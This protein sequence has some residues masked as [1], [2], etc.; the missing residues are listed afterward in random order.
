[1]SEK[2]PLSIQVSRM[3]EEADDTGTYASFC[4]A[5]I[6]IKK[7]SPQDFKILMKSKSDSKGVIFVPCLKYSTDSVEGISKAIK[8]Y[9]FNGG[10]TPWSIEFENDSIEKN[11]GLK[12]RCDSSPDLKDDCTIELCAIILNFHDFEF[13]LNTDDSEDKLI[14]VEGGSSPSRCDS[15]NS[16]RFK[17]VTAKVDEIF[18]KQKKLPQFH[19]KQVSTL[20]A[21]KKLKS[22]EI[23]TVTYVGPDDVAN[24]LT[25]F[26]E[27]KDKLDPSKVEIIFRRQRDADTLAETN[28]LK[29]K[30][31]NLGFNNEYS[32]RDHH[33]NWDK[34][35]LIVDT[36][37][38]M[39]WGS[40]PD[41]MRNEIKNRVDCLEQNGEL[42][43]VF[44]IKAEHFNGNP[45]ANLADQIE[46]V[47]DEILGKEVELKKI[48]TNSI[49]N[50]RYVILQKQSSEQDLSENIITNDTAPKQDL[51]IDPYTG[52]DDVNDGS[53]QQLFRQKERTEKFI[54]TDL[55]RIIELSPSDA[56]I[57]NSLTSTSPPIKHGWPTRINSWEDYVRACRNK[58]PASSP[59]RPFFIEVIDEI[60]DTIQNVK[61]EQNI[62]LIQTH[63]GWGKT[64]IVGEAIFPERDPE[65]FRDL[66][67]WFGNLEEL[68]NYSTSDQ[69]DVG[70]KE[71]SVLILDSKSAINSSF[72]STNMSPFM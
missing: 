60:A 20:T 9:D 61:V 44:P 49:G 18:E 6:T 39:F 30:L 40:E 5:K 45:Q 55:E 12:F 31:A 15:V 7:E 54:D 41:S 67:I 65:R 3:E 63:P 26:H 10:K 19:V 35:D 66:E 34:C 8:V 50:S 51:F 32:E 72:S 62:I 46:E 57:P 69:I 38:A 13:Y 58:N 56:K 71:N 27:L 28:W 68:E 14:Q 36:Y 47:I 70:Q 29:N 37:T 23:V 1:M 2:L 43:L 24:L 25:C 42:V 59:A 22:K 33:D 11:T 16:E 17:W 21:L 52:D 48:A 4:T 53:Q 64:S